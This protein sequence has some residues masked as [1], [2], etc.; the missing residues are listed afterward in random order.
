MTQNGRRLALGTA[1]ALLMPAGITVLARLLLSRDALTDIVMLYLLGVVIVSLRFGFWTSVASAAGSVLAFDV[2]FIRPYLTLT[3]ADFRHVITFG[4]ML[5]VAV[6]I[7]GLAQ[8]VRNQEATRRQF[9]TERLR[10]M[11]LSS[12]SHDLRTPL[13]VM[14][15]A[16]SSLAEV[17]TMEAGARREL[18]LAL[19]EE[20]ERLEH[21]VT[22][23][24]DMTR[25]QAGDVKLRTE[26]QSVEELV[27][28]ALNRLETVLRDHPVTVQGT[29]NLFVECDAS[30]FEQLL[31][32]LL[33]NAAKHTPSGTAI[34][35]S[36]RT[37]QGELKVTVHDYGDGMSPEELQ[38]AFRKFDRGAKR[39][40]SGFGLG[41]PICR[42]IAQAHGGA[43][44]AE[45]H[46]DGGLAFEVSLPWKPANALSELEEG[47]E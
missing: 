38:N 34:E 40:G 17:D 7:A 10:S 45:N 26:L 25:L 27:G 16:A 47:V 1:A 22:N 24:L 41:L 8:R 4:V 14:K 39:R 12:I 6:V 43:L 46:T 42:A 23:V 28:G 44:R 2:F 5:A 9:E 21:L 20:C 31:V 32:N 33:E 19:L 15:G 13:A 37:G 3:V 36:A 35:I 11:L 18:T 29:S 30:L